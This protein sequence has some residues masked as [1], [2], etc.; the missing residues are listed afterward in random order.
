MQSLSLKIVL[1]IFLAYRFNF[2][3]KSNNKVYF[4]LT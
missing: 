4:A 2:R 1:L 3:H